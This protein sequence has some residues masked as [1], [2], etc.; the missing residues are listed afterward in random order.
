[1]G[2]NGPGHQDRLVL[3]A[4]LHQRMED[5]AGL[6]VLCATAIK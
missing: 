5:H 6:C 1:M 4:L 3:Y 2:A